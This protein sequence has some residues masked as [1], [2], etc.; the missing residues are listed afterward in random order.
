MHKKD[1]G[2]KYVN[3]FVGVIPLSTCF[4]FLAIYLED[5]QLT[6]CLEAVI[7]YN[8]YNNL[9]ADLVAFCYMG[10]F[11]YR[12]LNGIITEGNSRV[13]YYTS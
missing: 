4:T 12:N 11:L 5:L 3:I 9:N 8:Y 6:L 7:Y 1:C 10:E 13:F 2:L